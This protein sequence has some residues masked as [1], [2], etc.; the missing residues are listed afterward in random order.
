MTTSWPGAVRSSARHLGATEP[1]LRKPQAS[2]PSA[3]PSL[4][5]GHG[6]ALPNPRPYVQESLG[7]RIAR[8]REIE[9]AVRDGLSDPVCIAEVL[10]AKQNPT[11]KRAAER[12]VLSHLS[13]L[14]T[15]GRVRACA[16]V[17][18]DVIAAS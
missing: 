17:R 14:E 1:V 18:G 13:K 12:N 3:G 7:R 15:E 10:Y 9:A 16:L 11:L 8:E 2:D 5:P 4:T 6:P